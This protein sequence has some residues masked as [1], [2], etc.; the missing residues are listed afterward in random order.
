MTSFQYLLS[1]IEFDA[2]TS[3]LY[4]QVQLS[5]SFGRLNNITYTIQ[6]I[7]GYTIPANG[8]FSIQFDPSY[9]GNMHNM[10]LKCTLSKGFGLNSVCR[11][12]DTKRLDIVLNGQNIDSQKLCEVVITGLNSPV[13]S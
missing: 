2:C 4:S 8:A 3:N 7:T 13:T 6:F 9:E 11:V 10:D 5:S 1:Q 12:G